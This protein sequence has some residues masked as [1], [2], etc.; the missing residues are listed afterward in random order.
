MQKNEIWLD[1]KIDSGSSQR[2]MF[3]VNE[4][5]DDFKIFFD[6]KVN[7]NGLD[8]RFILCTYE[9]CQ[10]LIKWM[11]NRTKYQYD[12]Q[13]Q[14]IKD[15]EG[16]PITVAVPK[17]QIQ[18]FFNV[19][20]NILNRTIN[21]SSGMY[22]LLFDNTYSSIRGK[23]LFLHIIEA[24]DEE[25]PGKDLSMIQHLLDEVPSDV[26]VCLEDANDC[27]V[28]GHYNQ[29]SV[30]LRKGIDLAIKI[31]LLQSGFKSNQLLDKSGNEIG[32]A[33]KIKLLKTKKLITQK[34]ASDIEQVKWFG[35]IGA[36][37]TMRVT[38][39]DISDNI[40]PKIRSFLVGLN[41]KA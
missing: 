2:F 3:H 41:L 6:S 33:S 15:K 16:Y 5:Q 14:V 25:N 24:W 23:N 31:K 30:M 20:T 28:A 11:N 32:L 38:E 1:Y 26:V 12:S 27:Y 37:G 4:N 10:K 21:L 35:D 22:T 9:D 29:C 19:R 39:Q 17:P 40:D 18:E 7:G 13:G 8:I 36:H 34:S